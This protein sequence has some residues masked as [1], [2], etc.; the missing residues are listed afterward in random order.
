MGIG[1]ETRVETKFENSNVR[2]TNSCYLMNPFAGNATQR[3]P[4]SPNHRKAAVSRGRDRIWRTFEM[5]VA[6]MSRK[7][8]EPV[9]L[10]VAL[11]FVRNFVLTMKTPSWNFREPVGFGCRQQISAHV[12]GMTRA[13]L[14]RRPIHFAF[15]WRGICRAIL[16]N[17][18]PQSAHARR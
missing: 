10:L 4:S 2:K 14:R 6:W 1:I 12:G 16:S 17:G 7:G 9:N 5:A 13:W 3:F 8:P 18:R 11:D 15:H